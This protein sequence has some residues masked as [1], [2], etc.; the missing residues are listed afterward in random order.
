MKNNVTIF[1][2]ILAFLTVNI[3]NAKISNLELDVEGIKCI[4]CA[5]E[6]KKHL[7]DLKFVQEAVVDPTESEVELSLVP[8]KSFDL[9]ALKKAVKESGLKLGEIELTVEGKIVRDK[10]GAFYYLESTGDKSLFSLFDEDNEHMPDTTYFLEPMY[11][12]NEHKAK[13]NNAF[14]HGKT[15]MVQGEIHEHVGLK[16]GL[17]IEELHIH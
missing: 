6:L 7:T 17:L 10:S 15:I 13:V 4:N 9:K 5:Q 16:T 2:L 3:A 12:N 14:K 1:A 11:L 8:G